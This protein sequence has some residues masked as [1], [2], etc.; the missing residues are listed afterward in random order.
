MTVKPIVCGCMHNCHI[1]KC[2]NT[3]MHAPTQTHTDADLDPLHFKVK[4]GK[5][6]VRPFKS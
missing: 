2:K 3:N 5:N 1:Y 4:K 6:G